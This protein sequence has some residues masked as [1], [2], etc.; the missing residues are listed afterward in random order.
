MIVDEEKPLYL[1]L[2]SL[3]LDSALNNLAVKVLSKCAVVGRAID[4]RKTCLPSFNMKTMPFNTAVHSASPHH[5]SDEKGKRKKEYPAKRLY[6][7]ISCVIVCTVRPDTCRHT[8]SGRSTIHWIIWN[9]RNSAYGSQHLS[10]C[11]LCWVG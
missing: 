2:A 9:L 4:I 3:N 10:Y 8:Y 1:R 7:L 11:A 5:R 6:G